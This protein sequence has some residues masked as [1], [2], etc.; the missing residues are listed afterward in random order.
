M[1][2]KKT[3]IIFAVLLRF[4][5]IFI[6]LLLL[7]GSSINNINSVRSTKNETATVNNYVD[8][9]NVSLAAHHAWA[10]SLLS[11]FTLGTS[12]TGTLDPNGCTLGSFLSD[13]EISRNAEFSNF[14]STVGPIHTRVHENGALCVELG[15]AGQA[16][17]ARIF[18]E[19]IEPDIELL[20][21][22]IETQEASLQKHLQELDDALESEINLAMIT[23]VVAAAAVGFVCVTTIAYIKLKIADPL[24]AIEEECDKLS[25]GDLNL[26]FDR[27]STVKE[28]YGLSNALAISVSELSRM[29]REIDSNVNELANK[30]FTVFPS[31]T[32]P[33]EFKSIEQSLAE[34]IT[35]IRATFGEIGMTSSQVYTASDQ[36]TISA[37]L[38]A[39]GSTEQAA[40]VDELSA[41]MTSMT[42]T[43]EESV[44]N[45]R[46]ANDLG[47]SAAEL[48]NQSS[49]EM[50]ELMQAIREIEESAASINNIIKTI[51][52][53]ASQTNILALNAAVEAARAGESGKGF[54]VVADE[55]RNLAQKSAE[56]VKNTT[57]LIE[58]CLEAVNSGAQLA[59][60]T[61]ES[62]SSMKGNVTEVIELITHI[63]NNL[64]EQNA[65][66]SNFA[67]G[68]DQI[69]AVVQTNTAT[70]E[71]TASTSEELNSQVKSLDRLVAEFKIKGPGEPSTPWDHRGDS[72]EE[73]F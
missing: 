26:K 13:P 20:A 38:L 22:A 40:T 71:E 64:E 51:S 37:Q 23:N 61:S 32:F 36:F 14:L 30:N 15:V 47:K 33:G 39:D 57:T 12:F 27:N 24:S 25:Q 21:A 70:S 53:I 72:D 45:A 66:L 17:A 60:H 67:V 55:V 29:I 48:M 56:A 28:V 8:T 65:S 46:S 44:Q 7:I 31:M 43:M 16:E 54:A 4:A 5:G 10:K 63:A 49:G 1:E 68:M 52:D 34:L 73:E 50:G 41:T 9:L 3:S 6:L 19:N 62:F 42:D 58:R 2:Q 11:S 69:S 59:S 18:R 35:G